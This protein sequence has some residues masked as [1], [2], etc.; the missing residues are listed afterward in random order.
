MSCTYRFGIIGNGFLAKAMGQYLFKLGYDYRAF[1]KTMY[2]L[3]DKHDVDGLSWCFESD[4]FTHVFNFAG[5]NGGIAFNRDNPDEIF[6]Q[7]SLI[8]LNMI[9]ASA[10]K[11]YKLINMI[12]SC[13]YGE[14]SQPLR[15]ENILDGKPENNVKAHGYARRNIYL[16]HSFY[17][18][19][20]R[21]NSICVCPNT[22]FGPGDNLD[23]KKAKVVGSLCSK[24][25]AAHKN[26]E[27]EVV[28]WGDGSPQRELLYIDDAVQ[29]LLKAALEYDDI[30]L[31]N[32]ADPGKELCVR[33]L[34]NI[35]KAAVGYKGDFVWDK[36]IP[37]GQMRKKLDLT[38]MEKLWPNFQ[39][40]PLLTAIKEAVAYYEKNWTSS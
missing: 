28:L 2:D 1:S 20:N 32:L 29:L 5:F 14:S 34:A 11:S 26:G 38:V 19:M 9:G 35:I 15:P 6:T 16:A 7:N 25:L 21:I 36:T 4:E 8:G 24:I 30:S 40:T 18:Q 23:P 39:F 22:I 17:R 31:L 13:A 12:T 27:A 33:D 37:N 10:G 3:T